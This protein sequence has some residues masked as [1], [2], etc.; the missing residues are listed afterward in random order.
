MSEIEVK[1]KIGDN[2]IKLTPSIVQNYILDKNSGKVTPSEF[3]T[4]CE[5]CKTKLLNPF[6]REVFLIKFGNSPAQIVVSKQIILKRA[7]S[8]PKFDGL[9]SGIYVKTKDGVM[10]QRKG[11]ILTQDEELLGAW[12]EVYRK[13][14]KNP[15]FCSFSISEIRKSKNPMWLSMPCTMSIK[16]AICRACRDAFPEDLGG[17]YETDEILDDNYFNEETGFDAQSSL[18]ESKNN[19]ESESLLEEKNSSESEIDFSDI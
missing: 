11:G 2:E 10:E 7:V 12:A 3:K 17:M 16:T 14:W 5:I 15:L 13:G 1:Y 18:E 6:T 19:L 9:N 8:N 4:F